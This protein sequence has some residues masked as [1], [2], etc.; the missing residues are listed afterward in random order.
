MLR[1][2]LIAFFSDGLSSKLPPDFP[3]IGTETSDFRKER[4]KEWTSGQS[5]EGGW[6]VSWEP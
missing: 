4:E 3:F 5:E 2:L 6:T 1:V